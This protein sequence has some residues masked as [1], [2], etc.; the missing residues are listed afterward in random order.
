MNEY[1][2]DYSYLEPIFGTEFTKAEDADEAEQEVLDYLKRTYPEA[3]DIKI[4]MVKKL[5]G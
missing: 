1:E 2:V 4:E 3:Q 5:N